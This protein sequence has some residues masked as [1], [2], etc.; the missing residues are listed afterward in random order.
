M[1]LKRPYSGPKHNADSFED[2]GLKNLPKDYSTFV[3]KSFNVA[4]HQAV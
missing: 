3:A 2:L 4:A 1:I